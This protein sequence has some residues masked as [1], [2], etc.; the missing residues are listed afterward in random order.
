MG[1]KVATRAAFGD[2]L[3]ALGAPSPG[4]RDRRRGRQLHLRGEFAKAYPDRY[5]EMFIAE[6]QMVGIGRRA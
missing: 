2:A 5:F 4:R 6:Q 3:V 1:T